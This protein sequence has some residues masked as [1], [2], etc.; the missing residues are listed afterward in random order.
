MVFC[1]G[2]DAAISSS[3]PPIPDPNRTVCHCMQCFS[4]CK[5]TA[6]V[7]GYN[8]YS[9]ALVH[10]CFGE[11][12]LPLSN[13]ETQIR[14]ADIFRPTLALPISSTAKVTRG[15]AALNLFC[16]IET[17]ARCQQLQLPIMDGLNDQHKS[18]TKRTYTKEDFSI[19]N[20]FESKFF[21][22]FCTSLL[23]FGFAVTFQSL[24]SAG[25]G[26]GWGYSGHSVEAI[27]FTSDTDIL[28]GGFSLFGGRG[29]YMGKIKVFD[30]GMVGGEQE[31]DGELLAE[32][33]EV[34]YECGAR[35]RY[36]VLFSQPVPLQASRWYL[37][38][39][40]VNGPSSDCGSGGQSII[41]TEDQYG[42]L[43]S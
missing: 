25:H 18:L 29:E 19:V 16:C 33:D 14:V 10:P 21:F 39:A 9:S 32:T 20:R 8:V 26:G 5:G 7:Q 2:E 4:I 6:T 40:R 12:A 15:Q 13:E 24:I 41:V 17:L 23:F 3:H 1:G 37:A 35:Q 22:H 31:G 28:L 30:L 34:V 38:W 11:S 36:P 27:R 43:V 42:L